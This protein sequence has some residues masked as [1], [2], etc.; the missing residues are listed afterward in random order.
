M[1]LL[2]YCFRQGYHQQN[3][4]LRI[5]QHYLSI[6]QQFYQTHSHPIQSPMDCKDIQLWS[7]DHLDILVVMFPRCTDI[8]PLTPH[9][10]VHPLI[11]GCFG[12]PGLQNL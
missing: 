7:M 10:P 9:N 11:Y 6:G 12:Y 2:L 1:V 4:P 3:R 5:E 8:T